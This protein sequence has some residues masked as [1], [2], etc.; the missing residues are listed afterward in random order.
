M[1]KLD[2]PTIVII[3]IIAIFL[4]FII[5]MIHYGNRSTENTFQLSEVND[6]VYA[7]YYNTH[8]RVPAQNYEV[9]TVRCTGN[10]YT[11]KG[12]V[13]ISY[14]DTEPYA[15]VKQYNLVN[16][17][18]VHIYVP[19]GTVAYEESVNISRWKANSIGRNGG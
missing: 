4:L 14:V 17:D 15:T 11:F 8:S 13:Q 7:I 6:G 16:S 18:E 19:K 3:G 10:I 1:K 2:K 5:C 9:I 12:S